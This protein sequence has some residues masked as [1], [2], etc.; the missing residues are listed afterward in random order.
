[1]TTYDRSIKCTVLGE[2]NV[3]KSSIIKR[4]TL[5]TFNNTY[6][7]TIGVEF[8]QQYLNTNGY[9]TKFSIWDTAGQMKFTSV[10]RAYTKYSHVYMIVFDVTST[11]PISNVQKYIDMAERWGHEPFW[12]VLVG[13]KCDATDERKIS[14]DEALKFANSN[15]IK[16]IEVSAKNN[17]N[18]DSLFHMAANVGI[19]TPHN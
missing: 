7:P 8:T 10:I 11:N 5:N 14:Y 3:G 18:I 17:I 9:I 16:Y 6:T 4:Y 1:M 15:G 12:V 19:L 13:N 2:E